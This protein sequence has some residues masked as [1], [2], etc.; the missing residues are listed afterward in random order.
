MR[1]PIS[2]TASSRRSLRSTRA[3]RCDPGLP[4]GAL[5][6]ALPENVAEDAFEFAVARLA[7]AGRIVD[8]PEGIRAASHSASLAGGDAALAARIRSEARAAGLEPPSLK[9]WSEQLG[10]PETQLRAIF[11][12]LVREGTLVAAPDAFW[13]DRAA[14][15]ALRERVVAHLKQHGALETPAYKSLIGTHAQA[16]RAADGALRSGARDAARGQQA[17]VARSEVNVALSVQRRAMYASG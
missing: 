10:R 16:R 3:S 9:E 11:A 15:D 7:A 14:V 6:G 1:A 12:L 5:A 17:G 13:F 8:A 4:R 2:N